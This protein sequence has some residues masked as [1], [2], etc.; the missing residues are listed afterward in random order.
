MK[1]VSFATDGVGI[2]FFFLVGEVAEV[3]GCPVLSMVGKDSEIGGHGWNTLRLFFAEPEHH[4]A[5]AE[6]TLGRIMRRSMYKSC[7]R[8]TIWTSGSS[9]EHFSTLKWASDASDH[10]D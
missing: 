3:P 9:L 5:S 6:G 7:N 2:L 8:N 4:A 1:P 10:K